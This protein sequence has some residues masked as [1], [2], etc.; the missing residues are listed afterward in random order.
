MLMNVRKCSDCMFK[1]GVSLLQVRN[2]E[3]PKHSDNVD[4]SIIWEPPW[5]FWNL[6]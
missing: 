3:M 1:N 4:E 2:L 5:K 6:L